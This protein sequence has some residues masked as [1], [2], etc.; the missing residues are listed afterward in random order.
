MMITKS[1]GAGHFADFDLSRV[2]SPAF[3]IDIARLED[4]LR[5]LKSV[6]KQA[7]VKILAALKACS[8][9]SV[10]PLISRYLD[11][12]CASGLYEARLA[13]SY[14]K[15]IISCFSPAYKAQHMTD[16]CQICDHIILNSPAQLAHYAPQIKQSGKQIGLRLNPEMPLAETPKYDPSAAGSHLGVPISQLDLTLL[17]QIDGLHIHNLCEQGFDALAKTCAAIDKVL[18][19]AKGQVKWLNLGGGHLIT[20]DD[21]DRTALIEFLKGLRARYQMQIYL[22]PGTALVFDAGIL[23]GEVLDIHHND[24]PNAILDISA[25]CHMPDVL[26]APYRPALLGEASEGGYVRLCGPSCM[27]GDVI[28]RYKFTTPPKIGTRLAF[29]DQAHYSMVKTTM[30]NGVPHPA[31]ILWDSRTDELKQ[32]KAFSYDDFE[33]RLS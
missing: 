24:G 9:W 27:A 21:Y 13:K 16:L 31:I 29:L 15:G 3:V 18:E 23:A 8:L 26:E 19:A 4:N 25:T 20:A 11:G 28:G 22:E 17:E 32:I 6:A 5:L 14:Y 12:A 1:A 7:D 30:F 2:N 10:A 33:R